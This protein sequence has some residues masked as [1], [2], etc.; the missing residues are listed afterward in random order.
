MVSV[1]SLTVGNWDHKALRYGNSQLRLSLEYEWPRRQCQA[2]YSSKLEAQVTKGKHSVATRIKRARCLYANAQAAGL[3]GVRRGGQL[4]R[5]QER[6]GRLKLLALMILCCFVCKL[7]A[8]SNSCPCIRS[9][10]SS[11]DARSY[12]RNLQHANRSRDS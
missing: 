11:L 1:K 9:P 2:P 3:R 4:S 10:P 7:Q 6:G 12:T 5:S 8:H